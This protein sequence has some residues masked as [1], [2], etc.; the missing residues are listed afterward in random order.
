MFSSD[1]TEPNDPP[2]HSGR[3]PGSTDSFQS[4]A[5]AGLPVEGCHVRRSHSMPDLSTTSEMCGNMSGWASDS[6]MA[7][8]SVDEDWE[9]AW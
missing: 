6:S 7:H 4:V 3:I 9:S 5:A 1:G 8:G 2:S